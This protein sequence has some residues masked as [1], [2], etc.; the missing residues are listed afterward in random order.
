MKLS[1]RV[2]L[3]AAAASV[4][5]GWAGEAPQAGAPM[6]FAFS[7][8]G[9]RTLSLAEALAAC[10][11]IGYDAVELALMPGYPAEP[12][13]LSRDDRRTLR[14][15]LAEERLALPA[16]MENLPLDNPQTARTTGDRLQ[17]AF[18]LGHDLVPA[19]PPLVETVLGGA[20]GRWDTLRRAFADGL[21]EWARLA[22]KHRTIV[23]IKPHRFGAMNL[24]EHALWLLEQ[25]RSPWIKVAYDYSHY[26][27]RELGMAQTL[28][29]LLPH[30][31]FVHVKDARIEN[32]RATFVLPGDGG[33]DYR[34]L[35]RLLREGGYRGPVCVEVSGVVQNRPD[36]DP[37][38]A[39]RRSYENLAPALREA[40]G[41]GR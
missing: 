22:E 18:E 32:G 8:Y 35:F 14:E 1:R 9:M 27:H 39:A 36:Y 19:S 31:R 21:A 40:N 26:Q 38:A 37:I 7:L 16:L 13:R 6:R 11:R 25:V 2:F 34:T 10:R 24:P 41:Q 20:V 23:A 17:A 12:R 30:T 4:S 5:R 3:A 15:K 29:A 33:I 28:K